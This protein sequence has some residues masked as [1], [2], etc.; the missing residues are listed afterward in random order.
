MFVFDSIVL[1]E[2]CFHRNRNGQD[3]HLLAW[4]NLENLGVDIH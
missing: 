1:L 3:P 2:G 4:K